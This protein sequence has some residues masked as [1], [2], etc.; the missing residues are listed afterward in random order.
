MS[1]F[2]DAIEAKILE[3]KVFPNTYTLLDVTKE[4]T[5]ISPIGYEYRVG[6]TYGARITCM[7]NELPYAVGNIV[8]Q[9]K[10][11]IYG[12]LRDDCIRLERCLLNR[13][14]DAALSALRDIE[15][16]IR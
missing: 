10:N 13:D 5:E 6:V 14:F 11:D 2:I 4:V 1:K 8:K 9:L 3:R 16:E 12:T 15:T 7:P